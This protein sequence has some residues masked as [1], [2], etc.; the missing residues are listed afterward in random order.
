MKVNCSKGVISI[1]LIGFMAVAPTAQAGLLGALVGDAIVHHEEEKSQ[2]NG[3]PNMLTQHPIM[4]A[5]AGS[6]AGA[7]VE[8]GIAHNFV[9]H[10]VRDSIIGAG[11][12]TIGA[13]Y[14]MDKYHCHESGTYDGIHQWTCNG[15]GGAHPWKQEAK[16]L[17]I[18]ART[19]TLRKNMHEA[20][21]YPLRVK[22]C[23]AHHIVPPDDGRFGNYAE[24]LRGILKTCDILPD[25]AENGV[26]LPYVKSGADCSGVY[27]PGL[28]GDSLGYYKKILTRL[29]R[30][31]SAG[32][33]LDESCL[34]VKN[35]LGQIKQDLMDGVNE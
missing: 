34:N 4:G 15:V 35:E 10:P 16:D 31:Y 23:A 2:Q 18:E 32:S 9:E 20:Y 27:H 33:N 28:H 17:Y 1:F 30:A 25:D 21:G 13:A 5:V 11:A 19:E 7:A 22:G 8:G 6:V 29:S 14:L 24:K 12:A 3:Q 26:W